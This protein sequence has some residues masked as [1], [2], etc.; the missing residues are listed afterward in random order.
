M[1]LGSCNCQDPHEGRRGPHSQ[2]S[3]FVGSCRDPLS[4]GTSQERRKILLLSW[5]TV[6]RVRTF[7]PVSLPVCCPWTQCPGFRAALLYHCPPATGNAFHSGLSDLSVV[8]RMQSGWGQHAAGQPVGDV[9]AGD[10]PHGK[11]GHAAQHVC[12]PTC[13][14]PAAEPSGGWGGGVPQRG[15]LQPCQLRPTPQPAG[16]LLPPRRD[17]ATPLR[18]T[19]SP[20]G[21]GQSS[22][23]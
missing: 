1:Y 5:D 8:R 10:A 15:Q 2:F 13:D 7:S 12:G 4:C 3:V 20:A 6:S 22:R 14:K 21:R 18:R 19:A 17:G 16:G 23:G 11:H 9:A